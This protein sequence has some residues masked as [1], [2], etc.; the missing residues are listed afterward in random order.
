MVNVLNQNA[1]TVKRILFTWEL[2][3]NYGHLARLMLV[4][5]AQ[6]ALGREVLFTVCNIEAAQALLT[7]K[8]YAYVI[9]PKVSSVGSNGLALSY[10]QML[11]SIGYANK[12][13]LSQALGDWLDIF[14]HYQPDL[15]VT[16]HSPTALLANRLVNIPVM[17]LGTGFEIPPKDRWTEMLPLNNEQ[18]EHLKVSEKQLLM[19]MNDALTSRGGFPMQSITDLFSNCRQLLAT[20]AELDHYPSRKNAHYIGPI[21]SVDEGRQVTWLDTQRKKVFVYAWSDLP[22][23][24][25]LMKVLAELDVEVIAVIPGLTDEALLLFSKPDVRIFKDMV[26]FAI[27]IKDADLLITHSGF[28]TVSAFLRHGIPVMVVPDSLEQFL[29]GQRVL[30]LGVGLIMGPKRNQE[31]FTQI[32]S[33]L[34]KVQQYATAA[35]QFSIRNKCWDHSM[36]IKA[37]T[38]VIDKMLNGAVE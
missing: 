31:S 22:G 37:V 17:Q 5:E 4:A 10:A 11:L 7:P 30:S 8:G 1:C 19:S 33:H 6:R 27:L 29:V 28:G 16:D 9:A 2:G 12:I 14:N 26:S 3:A 35:Q 36:P 38:C 32:I 21:Y 18:Q 23:I 24:N 25:Q 15:I 20:F 13:A 34:L